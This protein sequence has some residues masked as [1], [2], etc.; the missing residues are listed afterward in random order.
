MVTTP[1]ANTVTTSVIVSTTSDVYNWKTDN[2]ELNLGLTPVVDPKVVRPSEIHDAD[3]NKIADNLSAIIDKQVQNPSVSEKDKAI[4]EDGEK[5]AVMISVDKKP[6]DALIAKLRGY[7]A[8]IASIYDKLIYAISA[9]IPIDKINAIAADPEVTLIE[10]EG[11]STAHLDTST[12]NMGVRGSAYVWDAVPTIKGNP[13]YAIAILDTGVDSSHTDM[14]NF[15]YFHDFTY[16]GYP[17]GSTGVDYGHHGTHVASIAAGTGNA[18]TTPQTVEQTI[19]YHFHANVGW[20]YTTHWFEVKDHSSNPSTIV[21]LDWDDSGVSPS[22]GFGIMDSSGSSLTGYGPYTT[23]PQTHNLGNLAA[24]WYQVVCYPNNGDTTSRD[25]TITIEDEY[26]YTLGTEPANTP[27]FTGVAPQSKIV[28]LKVLD[29]TGSGSSAWLLNALNWVSVNGKDPA[30]NVTTVS[31]SLGFDGVY[32]SIDTAVNNLVDEG[33]ICVASA[34]ND[35]TN[36]GNNAVYSPGSAQKCITVGAVNDAYEVTYYSSNGDLVYNKPDVIAPGGTIAWSGSNSIHNLI[37]AADSNYGEED[38]SMIDAELNDYRG[39]Q[40]TS[41][42]CPHVSGLVQLAI[43]AIVQTEGS[44]TWSQ[45]NA[46]RIKQLICMGTW[47][48]QAGETFDGD[49]DGI[50]QNPPLNRVD[51][52]VVEGYGMVRGDAVIQ[53]I[54]HPTTSDF[55]NQVYDLDRRNDSYALKPKVLLFSFDAQ[56]GQAFNFSLDVPATGDFDLIIYNDEYSSSTGRPIVEMSSLSSGLGADESLLFIPTDA[57]TYYWSIRAVEGYGS[58]SVSLDILIAPTFLNPAP[59]DGSTGVSLSPSLSLTVSDADGDLM[60]VSFYNASDDSLLGDDT[61]VPSDDTASISWLGLAEGTSY[62][63]YAEIDDGLLTTKTG[64]FSFTTLSDNPTW[65][66]TPINQAVEVSD[67]FRYDLNASDT[68]GIASWWINDTVS[69]SI[70][71]NGVIRDKGTLEL[72]DYWLEVRVYDPYANYLSATFKVNVFISIPTPG[73]LLE[74]L[75]GGLV[76]M[77][78]VL[79]VKRRQK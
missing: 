67:A 18:D 27:V 65:D 3:G 35:G 76:V 9:I 19:S 4:S 57:G 29:D 30:Y 36:N 59:S 47:E 74:S 33:F 2:L 13:N 37:I 77:A 7:G 72:G 69:F 28:S 68:S 12:I 64:S 71:N 1:T 55:T 73:F 5:V 50:S 38:N 22:A 66:E 21:T 16:H 79:F 14:G 52:D 51:P 56:V 48:V 70:D 45:A 39:L 31:M 53:A 17:N 43:D 6:N 75:I 32:S 34:G 49:G 40:G 61:N 11:Y 15:L 54:T 62:S 10:K 25:Y 58:A 26:D 24:G 63:W 20:Y 42:S 44:W 78:L 60:D 8:E 41:M 46:L 23:S